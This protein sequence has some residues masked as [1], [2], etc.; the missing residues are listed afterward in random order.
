MQRALS[1]HRACPRC[2]RHDVKIVYWEYSPEHRRFVQVHPEPGTELKS[3]DTVELRQLCIVS[4]IT[5]TL[6]LLDAALGS[7]QPIHL[8]GFGF[9]WALL[10]LFSG[11]LGLKR[12][13][14][15]FHE[16]WTCHTC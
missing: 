5:V 3:S 1:Q 8:T 4:G 14:P 6:C 2:G 16:D 15:R 10:I 7:F 13:V 12:K 9:L 11:R